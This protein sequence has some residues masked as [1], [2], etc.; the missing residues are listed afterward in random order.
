MHHVE[1][2]PDRRSQKDGSDFDDQE[3]DE[4]SANEKAHAEL[5]CGVSICWQSQDREGSRVIAMGGRNIP[6][7]QPLMGADC[8]KGVPA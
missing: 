4:K 7:F 2:C 5:Q 8:N 1:N 3:G 6:A